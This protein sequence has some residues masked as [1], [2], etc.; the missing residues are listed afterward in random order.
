[1]SL[2]Q[3]LAVSEGENIREF[4]TTITTHAAP[5]DAFCLFYNANTKTVQALNGSG[6]S[7]EK[8][9]IDYV[10]Q[11]G[12]NGLEIPHMDLNCVTVPGQ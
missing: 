5:R 10:R 11:Q 8:L 3:V 4:G 7:P 1:M 2:S 9:T 6:H 12:I